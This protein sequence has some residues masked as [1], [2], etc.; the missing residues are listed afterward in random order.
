[1]ESADLVPVSRLRAREA[2]PFEGKR[3]DVDALADALA[4]E[5]DG[6]VRFDAGSRALYATDGS[7]YRQVPIGVVVPRHKVDVVATVDVCR[8]FGAP[9]LSRG[10]GTSLAGQCCNVAVVLDMS[11]HLRGILDLDPAGRR[12]R[13]LPGTVLDDLRAAANKHDL[14]FGPDPS[15][16]NHC[17]LGGM[18]G[19]NSC[20]VHS[21]MAGRTA[22]NVEELEVLTYD[23][24][25]MRVGAT[26]PAEVDAIVRAGG[27]RGEIHGRLRAL[28][29]RYGDLVRKQFPKIPRRVSGYN[30]DELL[31]ENGFHVAR[32]LVGTEGT[33]VTVLEATLRLVP[34]PRARTLLVLG[35]PDIY[36]A[37]DHVPDVMRDGPMG[38]EAIDQRLIDDIHKKGLH[39]RYLRYL[40]K[41]HAFLLVEFGGDTKAEADARAAVALARLAATVPRPSGKIYDD[42]DQEEKLWKVRESGLGATARIP[43]SPDTWEGWED[44][45]VPPERMGD[46]LR[47]LRQLLGSHGYDGA[48]YGHFGQGC[49]H[50]R[51]NFDLQSKGGIAEYHEFLEEA[52]ALVVRFGGSLSGEH[53]DGQ[54]R[55]E[56][57]P[58]MFGPELVEAFRAFKSIWDPDGRMNP[59]KV[60]DPFKADEN[61]RLG[62]DFHPPHVETHFRYPDD[63]G[64][65]TRATLRCV[66]VGECR[67]EHGGTMCPSY[68]ATRE[69]KHSTRGRAH[70][71]FEMMRGQELDGWRDEQVRES[72]DLC[73]ACKGCK[74]E[75]PVN[76]DVATYKAEFLAH[77]YAGRLRPRAAYAMGLIHTWAR[78]ASRAPGLVN[79][80]ARAPA[81]A[82]L[83]KR[84]AG[85]APERTLPLFARRTF[86]AG[87]RARPEWNVGQPDVVLWPDTFNDHFFPET[88]WAAVEVLEA[89]GY[90]VVVPDGDVCCGRPL[91]DFGML[92]AAKRRLRRTLASLEGAIASGVPIVG[93]EPSCVSVF[94]DELRGLM[95][96]DPRAARLAR[97]VVLFGELVDKEADRIPWPLLGG[98]AV[99][100]VH[101]HEKSLFGTEHQ[102]ALLAR[103]GVEAEILDAGCCGMAGSFGFERGDKHAVSIKVAELGILPA[104]RGRPDDT[105]I[106]AD[107]F[108]CR[109]QIRGLASRRA[110]HAA[111]VA[112]MAIAGPARISNAEEPP[113]LGPAVPA[114]VAA[115]T[116]AAAALGATLRR[117]RA[118]GGAW[119][120]LSSLPV[121]GTITVAGA[122]AAAL[123]ALAV[124]TRRRR[125]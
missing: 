112:Q 68:R 90:H 48:F 32:A 53:G 20:G 108:S 36:A 111:E 37:A 85:I 25:V 82:A 40:P 14:T 18:I 114:A 71:L 6:E 5:I 88:A 99:V 70:L 96:D 101:C 15:T 35:Y 95:P 31:P 84:V 1:M 59:G 4:R 34:W 76:V 123:A 120:W 97:Q 56:L 10:G 122:T 13:V 26:S 113:V 39:E 22:E 58:R 109:E 80:L 124:S 121:L 51:L 98:R 87:F 33:C 119:S 117:R 91:Y 67:R 94:R 79:L 100:Q 52:A 49:L 46:Y 9:V 24:D 28:I 50:T 23:G 86:R 103:L 64:D 62:A 102:R 81:T 57:L 75:C 110:L 125:G 105:L 92:D 93:L 38:L 3:L 78:L 8:R 116:W 42:A 21:I 54:S 89:M 72:L 77:H 60:V 61:L 73:L 63:D 47:E 27:R 74:G 66:G 41:G 29:A 69:E 106:I 107:G 55:A 11:K 30:L 115:V 45:A 17:T 7:N 2:R 12:A 65:F 83:I 19:N 104:V 44:S 16:H 118:R 43:G